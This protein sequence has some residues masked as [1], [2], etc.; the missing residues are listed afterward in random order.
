MY[1]CDGKQTPEN[2]SAKQ[3]PQ[4]TNA[5]M[6]VYSNETYNKFNTYTI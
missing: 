4:H 2:I 5:I 1:S 6:E 3:N